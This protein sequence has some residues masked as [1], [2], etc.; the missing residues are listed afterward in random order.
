MRIAIVTFLVLFMSCAS[1]KNRATEFEINSLEKV[2]S[3]KKIEAQ[4][5]FANPLSFNNVQG[6]ENLLPPGS[7]LGNINLMGNANYLRI[8]NDSVSM[9]LPYFGEQQMYRG[10]SSNG[11][12]KF[13]GIPRKVKQEYNSKKAAYILKY[14]L[15]TEIESYTLILTL[16]ASKKAVLNVNSSHITSINYNGDWQELKPK[17]VKK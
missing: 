5:D 16:Y 6:I 4:F 10:F 11:G 1:S 17:E 7:T 8:K 13:N 12:I 3:S 9:D 14:W 2:V 15:N